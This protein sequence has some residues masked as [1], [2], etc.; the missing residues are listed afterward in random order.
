MTNLDTTVVSTTNK[1]HSAVSFCD[2]NGLDQKYRTATIQSGMTSSDENFVRMLAYDP[3]ANAITYAG[4]SVHYPRGGAPFVL[5]VTP[6]SLSDDSTRI[7]TT[8]WVRDATGDFACNAATASDLADGSVLSMAK[9]GTG[10]STRPDA[11][12]NIL[13]ANAHV[14]GAFDFNDFTSSGVNTFGSGTTLT[15]CPNGSNGLLFTLASTGIKKQFF[16]RFGSL[17]VNDHYLGFRTGTGTSWSGWHKIFTDADVIPVA[18]GG[19]GSATKNFVDLSSDQTVAGAKAFSSSVGVLHAVERGTNPS[20]NTYKQFNF[21]DSTGTNSTQ[22]RAA[23]MESMISPEG[24]SYVYLRAYQWAS[25]SALN[26]TLTLGYPAGGSPFLTGPSPSS[27]ADDSTK[28]ATTEWVRDATGDFA[29]NAATVS[30]AAGTSALAWNSEVTLATVGG[31]AI[32]AKLPANPNTDA[33]VRQ[34]AGTSNTERPILSRYNVNDATQTANYAVYD[35]GVTSNPSRHTLTASGGFIGN[36]DGTAAEASRLSLTYCGDCNAALA[37]GSYYTDSS[38][39]NA[40]TTDAGFLAVEGPVGGRLVQTFQTTQIAANYY[41]LT[42]KRF[43]TL[44]SSGAYSASTS[45]HS[46]GYVSRIADDRSIF[47]PSGSAAV[48]CPP[49][50]TQL[51]AQS[52]SIYETMRFYHWRDA[53][54][55]ASL[56]SYGYIARYSGT[57]SPTSGGSNQAQ[58]LIGDF[59]GGIPSAAFSL[60]AYYRCS[61]NVTYD[62]STTETVYGELVSVG[63]VRGGKTV[64]AVEYDRKPASAP[65]LR[66][67]VDNYATL[68]QSSYRFATVYAGTGTINTSDERLKN[69][70]GLIPDDVLDA[71]GAVVWVQYQFNDAL[72]EKG[73]GAR[74]HTGAVAQRISEAFAARGLDASRYGLFC[75]DRWDEEW[76]ESEDGVR[77]KTRDA[78]DRYSLRYEEALS[79]EAAYLRREN[80]RLKERVSDLEDR[81]AALELR[82]GS[83]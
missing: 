51:P 83:A 80:A 43:V 68:G 75:Y 46:V 74:L 55:D 38:T 11:Q 20:S 73:G 14:S 59:C 62:D 18:N 77:T 26:A 30:G 79:M 9:G 70:I 12:A 7:P 22:R 58:F 57:T 47:M 45:W 5:G 6:A 81:L 65:W 66:Y 4:V 82:L 27:L 44:T 60:G 37:S 71:W 33:K 32:K 56:G 69:S 23:C 29:C 41:S 21:L 50:G 36:L 67:E 40:P 53:S 16:S 76:D 28:L 52:G 64:A 3:T 54:R 10:A 49:A 78:G 31:H 63:D 35:T 15:N 8:E 24:S 1:I 19:T 61:S 17:D 25:G 2:K 39:A 48:L 34:Y 72:E 42:Y 13:A